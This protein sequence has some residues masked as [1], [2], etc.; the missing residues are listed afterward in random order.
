MKSKRIRDEQITALPDELL[1]VILREAAGLDLRACCRLATTC[2]RLWTM[3]LPSFVQSRSTG[4]NAERKGKS[5]RLF[6]RE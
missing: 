5:A 1:E 2:K 4:G 6:Q 3:Q